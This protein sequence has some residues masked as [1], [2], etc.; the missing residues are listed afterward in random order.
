VAQNPFGLSTFG[1]VSVT[2]AFSVAETT[3]ILGEQLKKAVNNNRL[4]KK[5]RNFIRKNL[6]VKALSRKRNKAFR[7]T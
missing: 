1:K 5:M 6:K 2:G 4:E 3:F 7:Q